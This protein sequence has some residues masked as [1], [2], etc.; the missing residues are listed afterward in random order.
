MRILFEQLSLL[1]TIAFACLGRHLPSP[2]FP[3]LLDCAGPIPRNTE[4]IVLQWR[5]GRV[6]MIAAQRKFI[7]D[8]CDKPVPIEKGIVQ[9]RPLPREFQKSLAEW[10]K[11]NPGP[12]R[13]LQVFM[14]RPH[15]PDLWQL[16]HL[17][18]FTDINED[19]WFS[20]DRCA[21]ANSA[22]SW[23]AHLGRKIWFD[24][25]DWARFIERHFVYGRQPKQNVKAVAS[26]SQ[27]A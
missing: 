12:V 8:V 11:N 1:R 22:L 5:Y 6:L 16:G 7:C 27:R 21:D 23:T 17:D 13:S 3:E 24:S 26:K 19:Y 25:H 18:C 14:I 10:E 2:E 20:L 4:S 15:K 9:H